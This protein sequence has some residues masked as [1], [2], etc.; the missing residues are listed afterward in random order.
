MNALGYSNTSSMVKNLSARRPF[1]SGN[2]GKASGFFQKRNLE[3]MSKLEYFNS[4]TLDERVNRSVRL[5]KAKHLR[6]RKLKEY[7]EFKDK[8]KIGHFWIFL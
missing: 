2:P 4:M 1:H 5:D 7:K 3:H 8:V 6:S